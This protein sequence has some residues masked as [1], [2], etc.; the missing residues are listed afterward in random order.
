MWLLLFCGG[1]GGLGPAV[2][3]YLVGKVFII[4]CV[5]FYS[6]ELY[7]LHIFILAAV[8]TVLMLFN[9]SIRL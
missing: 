8:V 5:H 9:C 1:G 2:P 3:F 6:H 7:L 4:Y